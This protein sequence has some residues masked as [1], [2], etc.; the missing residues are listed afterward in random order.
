MNPNKAVKQS[1]FFLSMIIIGAIVTIL[2]LSANYTFLENTKENL[3]LK[4]EQSI[5][6]I[7]KRLTNLPKADPIKKEELITFKCSS[8]EKILNLEKSKDDSINKI[9][10]LQNICG[11]Y[12]SNKMFVFTTMPN[13]DA[14]A[15]RLAE[16]LSTTLKEYSRY[17]IIPVVIVE[18]IT[19]WGLIDFEEFGSG[20]YTGWIDVFFKTIKDQKISDQ[21]MGI[22]V[23]FPE[24][25]LPSWN[26]G[27][28]LP[29]QFG[30]NVTIY[31]SV[32][33]KYFP[34]TETSIMLNSVSYANEDY[35]WENGTYTS[36]IP[37][38]KTL[39]PGLVDSFGI[40]GFPWRSPNNSEDPLLI[41]NPREFINP[42]LAAEAA[43]YL[44]VK[45]IWV[46]TG[47]FKTKYANDESLRVTE[48]Y[49]KREEILNSILNEMKGLR[50]KGFQVS[51][52]IFAENKSEAA[53]A[54]DWSYWGTNQDDI[55]RHTQVLAK[56]IKKAQGNNIEF[57]FFNR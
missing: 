14:A 13:S 40:Q 37:Y 4:I 57:W 29:E 34:K 21:Q 24:A 6:D 30:T 38:L 55:D 25:N 8:K 9:H 27:E 7:K 49:K 56:F 1:L 48:T 36:L 19:S 5:D 3:S 2:S 17:G 53:E 15:K 45:K 31:L 12:V 41:D 43:S 46:N 51:I 28:A 52:N 11:S 47:T 44:K 26:R 16:G 20:F 35:N 23:P 10:E 39:K 33:R 32:L 54:T 18:P 22:W 42:D 50:D